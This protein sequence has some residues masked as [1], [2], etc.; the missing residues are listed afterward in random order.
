MPTAADW[1]T[2]AMLIAAP[3]A[4]VWLWRRDV[5]GPGSLRRLAASGLL[6]DPSAIS[7]AAWLACAMATF[8]SM[9]VGAGAARSLLHAAGLS[10]AAEK[11]LRDLAGYGLAVTVG[12]LC[13]ALLARPSPP[14]ERE[15]IGLACRPRDAIAG[16]GAILL[17]LPLC[18]AAAT[19]SAFLARAISGAP[20]ERLAHDTLRALTA[21]R[22]TWTALLGSALVVV[23]APLVEELVYR[24]FLQSA[25][26]S[27][28]A[29]LRARA[30][31]RE[32]R[33]TA[34]DAAAGIALAT[35]VFV[36]PHAA[37]LGGPVTWHALPSL[38]V[39]SLAMGLAYERTRSP[40]VPI[41]MHAGFNAFN[42]A[43]A[44]LLT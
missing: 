19:A 21:D 40:M 44:M 36:A 23:G 17:T 31:G 30:E 12:V 18:I 27:F 32:P 11:A 20:P 24:V 37:A 22:W 9:A 7:G 16:A 39:L 34:G 35:V 5:V 33:A 38:A 4:L 3:I 28:I 6:R 13:A 14:R 2:I 42:L 26:V 43:A 25:L 15:R 41:V 1:F 29:T 8:L 10:E